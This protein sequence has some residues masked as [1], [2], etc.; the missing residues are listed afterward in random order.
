[1]KCIQLDRWQLAAGTIL[2]LPVVFACAQADAAPPDVLDLVTDEVE[3]QSTFVDYTI[4]GHLYRLEDAVAG[5][6]QHTA[7]ITLNFHDTNHD[8]DAST[9]Y[10]ASDPDWPD[11]NTQVGLTWYQNFSSNHH[12]TT[13]YPWFVVY[14]QHTVA[15]PSTE[16]RGGDIGYGIAFTHTLTNTPN[17][18]WPNAED[19]FSF[20]FLTDVQVY[21]QAYCVPPDHTP[22]SDEQVENIVIHALA[23]EYGHQRA[24]LT[25]YPYDFNP[26]RS[27]TI[28]H[29]G[30]VP[31]GRHDVMEYNDQEASEHGDPVFD[32]TWNER[33]GDPPSTCRAILLNARSIH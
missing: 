6:F 16:C 23:H 27:T 20:V 8:I 14:A 21:E 12:N 33:V 26:P 24:G 10:N 22:S 25:H 11:P 18:V 1:M 4:L 19:R 32:A 28:Y 9:P 15:N 30:S 5:A 17:Y 3:T 7:A 29:Q 31:S 2:S 13:D